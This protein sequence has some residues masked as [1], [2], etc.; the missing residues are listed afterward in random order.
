MAHFS[1]VN[2]HDC[3]IIKATADK[4]DSTTWLNLLVSD[5]PHA[6]VTIFMPLERA[7]RIAAAINSVEREWQD[8]IAEEAAAEAGPQSYA[9]EHRLTARELV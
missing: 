5:Y 2:I 4:H 8:E 3:T 6:E 9:D 1:G 7:E